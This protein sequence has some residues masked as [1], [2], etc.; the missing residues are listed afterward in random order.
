MA[1]YACFQPLYSIIYSVMTE[2]LLCMPASVRAA[3]ISFIVAVLQFL[4]VMVLR[5]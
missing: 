3:L 1:L 2:T 4:I 5:L